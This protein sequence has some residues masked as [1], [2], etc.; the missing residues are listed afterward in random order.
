[1][2]PADDLLD[3]FPES[4]SHREAQAMAEKIARERRMSMRQLL[5]RVATNQQSM[6]DVRRLAVELGI[7]L[8]I[9]REHQQD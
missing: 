4:E 8:T 2:S 3:P 9:K 5:Q 7:P 6:D 1:M